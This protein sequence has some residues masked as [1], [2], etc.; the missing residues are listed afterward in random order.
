MQ[1]T[2][3]DHLEED[4]KHVNPSYQEGK[5]AVLFSQGAK[6]CWGSSGFTCTS[7]WRPRP[8]RFDRRTL[9]TCVKS[10]QEF[11]IDSPSLSRLPAE[12]EREREEDERRLEVK[13]GRSTQSAGR[14]STSSDTRLNTSD[15]CEV[16]THPFLSLHSH[17]ES[18]HSVSHRDIW[19]MSLAHFLN[20]VATVIKRSIETEVEK[21]K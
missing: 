9:Q 18:E 14:K 15:I 5:G 4:L 8:R 10:P 1:E 16:N 19:E 13:E 17:R 3:E 7:L 20:C 12:R 6:Q 2:L 21:T 11:V